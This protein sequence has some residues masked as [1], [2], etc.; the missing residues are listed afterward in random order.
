MLSYRRQIA[1][2]RRVAVQAL[3]AYPLADP[4]LR[5]VAHGE[6]TTF[7]V[8]AT[9]PDGRD[10]FLLRVHRPARHGRDVDP[11]AAVGSE[12][13]WLAALRADTDLTVPE[14]LRTI[15]GNL[16][17]T[18]TSA[19]VPEPR[20]CSVLRWM[21]GRVHAAAPRPVH[22]RRLGGVMARPPGRL[23]RRPRGRI[24]IVVH[25]HGARQPVRAE[26]R[27]P[28]PADPNKAGRR[29]P[30]AGVIVDAR[31]LGLVL[32]GTGS[33]PPPP[34]IARRFRD[35]IGSCGQGGRLDL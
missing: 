31:T 2:M 17:T 19:G 13:A 10:R 7:R 28:V 6:D 4:V 26:E 14:P 9:A 3:D 25:R 23:H 20:V 30:P 21:D 22:L 8:D 29:A 12:L 1:R 18:A 15:R 24:R 5:F 33:M 34:Q 27:L 35:A 16:T 32:Y 11:A